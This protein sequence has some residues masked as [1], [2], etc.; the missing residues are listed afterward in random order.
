MSSLPASITVIQSG[1]DSP[2]LGWVTGK[3]DR[4]GGLHGV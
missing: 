4:V 1:F 3:P 2:E